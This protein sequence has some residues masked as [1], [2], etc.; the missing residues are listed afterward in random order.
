MYWIYFIL[1]ILAILVPDL[2]RGQFYFLR[3]ENLEELIIFILGIAGFSIFIFK[4]KQLS[5]QKIRQ[6]IGHKKLQQT[7]KD[8]VDSY[9]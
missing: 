7:A 2:V 5:V 6:K 8:L 3:E 4:E 9:S 1:F